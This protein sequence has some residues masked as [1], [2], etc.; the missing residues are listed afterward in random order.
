MSR[1]HDTMELLRSDSPNHSARFGAIVVGLIALFLIV[2]VT[3]WIPIVGGPSGRVVR[4]EFASANQV[5]KFT[6]VRVAGVDVG[7]VESLKRGSSPG[8]AVVKMRITNDK[9][10]DHRDAREA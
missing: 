6:P 9:V 3:H 2:A 7:K 10:V 4:A 8:T 5:N 1:L